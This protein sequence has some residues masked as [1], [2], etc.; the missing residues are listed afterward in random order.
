MFFSSIKEINRLISKRMSKIY[1]KGT[2]EK[3]MTFSKLQFSEFKKFVS[4]SGFG[5]IKVTQIL[6]NFKSACSSLKIRG[7]CGFS[8]ILILKRI[9]T[10]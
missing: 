9:V 10:F 4:R 3:K 2:I 8:I 7:V 5:E 6:L 1:L